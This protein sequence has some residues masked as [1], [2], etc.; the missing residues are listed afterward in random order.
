[1]QS[2]QCREGQKRVGQVGTGS[3]KLER[4]RASRKGIVQIRM[5]WIKSESGRGKSLWGGASPDGMVQVRTGGEQ[6]KT[7]I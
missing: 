7:T 2:G 3:D 5:G 1:M 4:G 6:V